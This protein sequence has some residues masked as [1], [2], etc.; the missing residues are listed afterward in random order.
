MK[1]VISYGNNSGMRF[2]SKSCSKTVDLATTQHFTLFPGGNIQ[3]RY[4]FPPLY[5]SFLSK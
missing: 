2:H 5:G 4:S 3:I 1:D